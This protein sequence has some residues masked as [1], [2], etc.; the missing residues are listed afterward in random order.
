[1]HTHITIEVGIDEDDTM[2]LVHTMLNMKGEVFNATGRAKRNPSDPCV[3]I[4]GE[5][6]ALARAL[7]ALER[8]IID[9]AYA[10]IDAE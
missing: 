10:R 1:M 9:A 4:I 8:Q 2:T 6:L 5:E 7:S 3:P